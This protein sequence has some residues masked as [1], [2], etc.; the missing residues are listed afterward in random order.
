MSKLTPAGCI[1]FLELWQF[2]L[3]TLEEYMGVST[4]E[5]KSCLACLLQ[6]NALKK[7]KGSNYTKTPKFNEMLREYGKSVQQPETEEF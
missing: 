3:K 4:D 6:N 1:K 5:A 2:N 7:F